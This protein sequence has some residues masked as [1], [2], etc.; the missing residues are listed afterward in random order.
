VEVHTI[1]RWEIVRRISRPKEYTQTQ[2][3]MAWTC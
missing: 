2:I 3:D 1:D